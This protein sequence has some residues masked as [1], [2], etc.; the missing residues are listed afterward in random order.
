MWFFFTFLSTFNCIFLG[1][2]LL[3]NIYRFTDGFFDYKCQNLLAIFNQ[4]VEWPEF[5]VCYQTDK[6]RYRLETKLPIYEHKSS[7][8]NK[9]K[10]SYNRRT[11]FFLL[12]Y[13]AY[14]HFPL[15]L[16]RGW[17]DVERFLNNRILP[18]LLCYRETDGIEEDQEIKARL[19]EWL[20]KME[21][22][23]DEVI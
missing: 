21:M 3:F 1:Q 4:G 16:G 18:Y 11:V 12:I 10:L 23:W 5:N 17:M 15:G 7:M 20:R 9:K 19:D 14:L 8:A 2:I 22:G 13:L 6:D